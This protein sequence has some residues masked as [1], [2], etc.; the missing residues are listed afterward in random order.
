M[1]SFRSRPG[2]WLGLLALL[3]LAGC[4]DVINLDLPQ[5]TPLLA[6][7][8]A[9]TD[10]PGPYLVKLTTTAPYFNGSALPPVTGAVL[11]LADS[12]GTTETLRERSP[13]QYVSSRLRGQIGHHYTLT[14]VAGD[15]TYRAKTE[16][17]RTMTIDSLGRKYMEA[18]RGRDSMGYQVTLFA[19]ELAGTGD[20]YRYKVYRNGRLWDKPE[21]LFTLSDEFV[22][23]KYLSAPLHQHSYQPGQ[24]VRVEINAIT[25]DYYTFLREVA[26]QTNNRGIFAPPPANVRTNVRNVAAGSAKVAVGYFAGYA[27]R[28]DSLIIR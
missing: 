18:N 11:T 3:L 10:Q 5:G 17:R 7:D 20:R 1:S 2:A 28:A 21:D 25:Q 4:T 15:Q 13:G 6:V 9:I 12:A 19:R 23:G 24:R 14:I 8:G 22:E 16:I 26:T 27:V